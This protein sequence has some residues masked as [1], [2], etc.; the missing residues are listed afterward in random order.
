MCMD[1]GRYL[2]RCTDMCACLRVCVCVCPMPQENSN[3]FFFKK[4]CNR[5]VLIHTLFF[6]FLRS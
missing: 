5:W 3:N 4:H 2:H 1:A 6:F